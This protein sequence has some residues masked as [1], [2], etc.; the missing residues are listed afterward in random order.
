[1]RID[2][3]QRVRKNKELFNYRLEKLIETAKSKKLYGQWNDY[4]WFLNDVLKNILNWCL[5]SNKNRQHFIIK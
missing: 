3:I 5:K 4:D 1:M 2:N